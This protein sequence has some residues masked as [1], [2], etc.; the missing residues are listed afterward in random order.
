MNS[1]DLKDLLEIKK[2]A[3]AGIAAIL[4]EFVY[5]TGFI[6]DSVEIDSDADVFSVRIKA[7]L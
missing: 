4:Q 1:L 3:E 6:P 7:S 5:A 2:A